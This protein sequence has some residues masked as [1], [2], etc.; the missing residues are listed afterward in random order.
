MKNWVLLLVFTAIAGRG[1]SQKEFFY[2]ENWRSDVISKKRVKTIAI[3]G[4]AFYGVSM[5]SL[6]STWY[7]QYSSGSF[8]TFDDLHEW[9]G[10]D[11][12]GHLATSYTVS[13][14]GREALWWSGMNNTQSTLYGAGYA[15]LF[16]TTIEIF[17]GFSEGWGFS[18][19]DVA[20]NTLGAGVFASQQ[21]LWKEQR[22][23]I[24]YSYS[25]SEYAQ[26]R[27]NLLG[28]SWSEKMLKDYNGQTYWL[29]GNVSSFMKTE[30]KFPKWIN[31]AVGYGAGGMLGGHEN[32]TEVDGKPVPHFDRYSQMYFSMD[33]DFTRIKTRSKFLKTAFIVLSF[34]KVPFPT[35]EL[36][37]KGETVFH[38]IMF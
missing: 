38:G 32:P 3:T 15:M 1:F 34:V 36:N 24:K 23:T 4:G 26:Y 9:E 6:Y 11:K 29:S 5:A 21:L 30:T 28:S 12:V 33:V 27:P 18:W 2:P 37:K 8:H 10:M 20:A 19:G 17:D 35:L 25:P 7:K 16:Q 22:I 13:R 14:Y 31:F